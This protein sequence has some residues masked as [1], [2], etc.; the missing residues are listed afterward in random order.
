MCFPVFQGQS[1]GRRADRRRPD[2]V[3]FHLDALG[4]GARRHRPRGRGAPVEA[5]GSDLTWVKVAQIPGVPVHLFG[6]EVGP[7]VAEFVT[8]AE[9]LLWLLVL[10]LWLHLER[11]P[12][13]VGQA[14][15]G[16]LDFL[17]QCFAQFSAQ[18]PVGQTP[19]TAS[20]RTGPPFLRLAAPLAAGAGL[21]RAAERVVAVS[22]W[23]FDGRIQRVV[24][25]VSVVTFLFGLSEAPFPVHAAAERMLPSAFFIIIIFLLLFRLDLG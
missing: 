24:S 20:L 11:L 18:L 2:Y 14:V 13:L 4:R 5:Q 6:L 21:R 9:Q 3:P 15:L 8:V 22:K 16:L 19:F 25:G 7:L 1:V 10:C 12:V 17:V 23:G